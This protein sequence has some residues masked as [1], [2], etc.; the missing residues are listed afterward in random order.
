MTTETSV[1]VQRFSVGDRVLVNAGRMVNAKATV[2]A[3]SFADGATRVKPDDPEYG[4]WFELFANQVS[5]L[6]D[7]TPAESAGL[8]ETTT[9]EVK[10]DGKT[11]EIVIG[12]YYLGGSFRRTRLLTQWEGS[13]PALLARDMCGSSHSATSDLAAELAHCDSRVPDDGGFR[14]HHE[15]AA[16]LR[17][18]MAMLAE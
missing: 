9:L 8:A 18:A 4:A 1:K 3:D 7:T 2:I 17:A 13:S 16:R 14:D 12:V 6:A 11:R 5:P 15:F 10:T